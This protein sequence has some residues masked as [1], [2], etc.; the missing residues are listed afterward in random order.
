[1]ILPALRS[2]R[3]QWPNL[4]I[5]FEAPA[6]YVDLLRQYREVDQV[7]PLGEE[8]AAGGA[9]WHIDLSGY[10]ERHPEARATDRI[11]LFGKAFGVTVSG[12]AARCQLPAA[13]R[14]R[15]EAWVAGKLRRKGPLIGI[16]LR[17]T[18]PYRSWP[19]DHVFRTVTLLMEKRC[20][21][22]VFDARADG[23]RHTVAE[24]GRAAWAYGLSLVEVAALLERCEAAITPDTG[25]LHLSAS[26][27]T[28]FV[29]IFGPIPPHLLDGSRGGAV[30]AL[31]R[32][33]TA[34]WVRTEMRV[35]RQAGEGSG[36]RSEV[37]LARIIHERLLSRA[38]CWSGK[39]MGR[40]T[41]TPATGDCPIFSALL[42]LG[43]ATG[44]VPA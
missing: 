8:R 21:V 3:Q 32:G 23:P 34:S 31:S 43:T 25:L 20:R 24:E 6:A 41:T 27:G 42:E 10:V 1:M 30:C 17:G 7:V 16:A 2:L 11:T 29:G 44:F 35:G 4:A 26:V 15:A 9:M 39:K 36:G 5:T 12:G 19:V 33:C 13:A 40:S 28:P 22:I 18:Y 38:V 37:S 14:E